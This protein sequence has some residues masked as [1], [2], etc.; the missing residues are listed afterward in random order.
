MSIGSLISFSVSKRFSPAIVSLTTSAAGFNLCLS[1]RLASV[2]A[3]RSSSNCLL[4]EEPKLALDEPV[5]RS[6]SSLLILLS[7]PSQGEL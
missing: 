3:S 4:L 7:R 1:S 5:Y 6:E 2:L